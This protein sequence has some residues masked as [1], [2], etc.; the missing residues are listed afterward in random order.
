MSVGILRNLRKKFGDN[1]KIVL[2]RNSATN[3]IIA[4][5]MAVLIIR[6]RRSDSIRGFR[7]GLKVAEKTRPYITRAELLPISIVA[8]YCPGLSVN[9]FNIP[10]PYALCFLS[11]S[12]RSLFEVTKAISIPEKNADRIIA[13]KITRMPFMDQR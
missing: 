3:R 10:D 12:M 9:I 2:G 7:S 6:T 1:T 4:V 5:E 11:S 13:S 8:I